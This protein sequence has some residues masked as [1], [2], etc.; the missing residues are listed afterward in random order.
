MFLILFQRFCYLFFKWSFSKYD[1]FIIAFLNPLVTYATWFV[2]GD[3]CIEFFAFAVNSISSNKQPNIV[4]R[5]A[6]L[7]IALLGLISSHLKHSVILIHLF[8]FGL[9]QFDDKAI[10]ENI[11]PKKDFCPKLTFSQQIFLF[12]H[13]FPQHANSHKE[14][15]S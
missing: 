3:T 9:Q 7:M 5:L 8:H 2:H 12:L 10:C 13:P 4:L 1:L 14:F 11:Q 6:R 15:K